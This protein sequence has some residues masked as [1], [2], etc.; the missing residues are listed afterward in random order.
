MAF[1]L[2]FVL[3]TEYDRLLG[4]FQALQDR[5][6]SY[7]SQNDYLRTEL[8]EARRDATLGRE[9]V[10]DWLA[11]QMFGRGIFGV[12]PTLPENPRDADLMD[13]IISRSQSPRSRALRA[14]A[15]FMEEYK[16]R[17]AEEREKLASRAAAG[18]QS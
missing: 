2:P 7:Q 16:R 10:A 13:G 14:E 9:M 8:D 12:A 5:L 4:D 1:T 11:Q 3:R 6:R 15:E 18:E 17:V